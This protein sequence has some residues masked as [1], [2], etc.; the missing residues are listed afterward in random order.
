MRPGASGMSLPRA[1]G[2]TLRSTAAAL[3]LALLLAGCT[4]SDARLGVLPSITPQPDAVVSFSRDIEPIF[5]QT[6]VPSQTCAA[7]FCHGANAVFGFSL[8][9]GK[10]YGNLVNVRSVEVP[11]LYRVE[12]GNSAGSYLIHKLT[13]TQSF[14]T[15]MPQ[16]GPALD[17]SLIKLIRDWIDQG[18]ENN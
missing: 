15:P 4:N 2:A 5:T 17:D 16:N 3:S 14:G 8:E 7:N 12:P 6:Q 9:Q 18:A 10:A 1:F 13:G 11:G